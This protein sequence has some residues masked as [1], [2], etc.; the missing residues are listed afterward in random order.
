MYQSVTQGDNTVCHTTYYKFWL[1]CPTFFTFVASSLTHIK[2]GLQKCAGRN[3]V[4][5]SRLGRFSLDFQETCLDNFQ[6]RRISLTCVIWTTKGSAAVWEMSTYFYFSVNPK[7]DILLR[8]KKFLDKIRNIDGQSGQLDPEV[9]WSLVCH[10]QVGSRGT[11]YW[12]TPQHP[13]NMVGGRQQYK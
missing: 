11:G 13:Q 4:M 9:H 1:F 5:S 10:V 2:G 12:G 7:L 8:L 6:S 3:C